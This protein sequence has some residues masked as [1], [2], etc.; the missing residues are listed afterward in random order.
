MKVI[1]FLIQGS[2]KRVLL[3]AVLSVLASFFYLKGITYFKGIVSFNEENMFAPFLIM[4][5]FFLAS[6]IIY[7][8]ANNFI[9]EH[10]ELK[11]SKTRVDYSQKVLK[12]PYEKTEVISKSITP[13]LF[14]DTVTLGVFAKTF[15]E[16]IVS[17]CT[18]LS[19]WGYMFTISWPFTISFILIFALNACAILLTQ[20]FL[21]KAEQ[22]AVNERNLLHKK[23]NGLVSGI[24]ELTLNISHKKVY[25]NEIIGEISSQ[26]AQTSIKRSKVL[27]SVN[28][29][30]ETFLLISFGLL[31]L[32]AYNNF[33]IGTTL[34]LEFFTM[35]TFS[36][37]SLIKIGLFF[38]NLKKAEVAFEQLNSLSETI[39]KMD[40]SHVIAKPTG[41]LP[42]SPPNETFIKI[43]DITYQYG[44]NELNDFSVGP[45]NFE[46]KENEMLI[47][48]GGN[49]SG[50]T[51]LIKLLMGLYTPTSG[52]IYFKNQEISKE[53][54]EEYRNNFSVVF[55]DSFVFQ[56]LR[57]IKHDRVKELAKKYLEILEINDKVKFDNGVKLS[58]TSLSMGQMSRLNLFRALLEDKSI[59]VFDEWA[60]N[61]DPYFK[62]KFYNVILPDLKK[63]GKTII[64]ISHDD[65]YY[66]I[67]DRRLTVSQGVVTKT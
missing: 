63:D 43:Q 59:Y 4:A 26:Y 22:K 25:A 36:L 47:I 51:T 1:S 10:F 46:I 40:N 2:V 55:A 33:G 56:D 49:G 67:S 19:I 27:L 48:K 38:S 28:K 62:A 23:L 20:K 14:N 12:S 34:F 8:L 13:I 58:T 45:F 65:K 29:S 57:Y 21:F 60:A 44:G 66:H 61:Q 18:L 64:A 30:S 31:V 41:T 35:I 50:K 39:K 32:I 15:P 7:I 24:K 3:T 53:N 42:P 11:I 9:T 37:P 52:S 17:T 54:L 6:S 16:F 5:S